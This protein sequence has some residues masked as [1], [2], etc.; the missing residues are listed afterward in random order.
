MKT[1]DSGHKVLLFGR[2]L[3]GGVSSSKIKQ[4]ENAVVDI[5]PFPDGYQQLKRLK[6][7]NLVVLDY[8]PFSQGGS[9]YTNEQNVF[10]K[11]KIVGK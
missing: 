11:L 3:L 2:K 4:H 6:D 1:D 9:S 7:Y 10:Y 5:I 8:T